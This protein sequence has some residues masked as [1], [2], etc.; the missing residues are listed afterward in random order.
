MVIEMLHN[1]YN[2]YTRNLPDICTSPVT[3]KPLILNKGIAM[4]ESAIT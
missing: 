3:I 2:I 4:F 1:S